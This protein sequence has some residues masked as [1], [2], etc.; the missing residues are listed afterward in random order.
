MP[1]I[2]PGFTGGLADYTYNLDKAKEL[3]AKAGVSGVKTTLAYNAGDPIQEPIAIIY[4]SALRQIGVELELKKVP[5]GSFYNS[6]PS[7]SSR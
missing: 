7:A 3:M 6:S 2:Y 5:A 4:Q 1:N